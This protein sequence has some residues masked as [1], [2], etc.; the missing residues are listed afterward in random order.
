MPRL[1][2]VPTTLAALLWAAPSLLT[3]QQIARPRS[4]SI[5]NARSSMPA[6]DTTRRNLGSQGWTRSSS[7][8]AGGVMGVLGGMAV[9]LW[10]CRYRET[11]TGRSC[12]RDV[13]RG[14]AL[15]GAVGLLLGAALGENVEHQRD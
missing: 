1:P 5:W 12:G 10:L 8:A 11:P 13:P 4:S 3:A 14:A 7:A 6:A 15:L 9:G 2:I